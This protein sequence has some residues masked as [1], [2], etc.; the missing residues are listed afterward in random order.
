MQITGLQA[1]SRRDKI[2]RQPLSTKSH[3]PRGC[4]LNPSSPTK[5]KK[6]KKPAI[7]FVTQPNS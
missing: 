1:G 3:L 7:N 4:H 6:F 2:N 5:M